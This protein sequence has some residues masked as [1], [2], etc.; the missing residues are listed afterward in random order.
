MKALLHFFLP[1]YLFLKHET[2]DEIPPIA[3]W[4]TTKETLKK[5]WILF[6]VNNKDTRRKYHKIGCVQDLGRATTITQQSMFIKS[7]KHVI[8]LGSTVQ[9]LFKWAGLYDSYIFKT[10][11]FV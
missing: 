10:K 3:F 4:K 8:L 1:F 11:T 9:F 7:G 2:S 6:K 5:L